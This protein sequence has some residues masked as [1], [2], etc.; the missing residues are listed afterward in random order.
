M[1]ERNISKENEEVMKRRKSATQRKR[2]MGMRKGIGGREVRKRGMDDEKNRLR[3]GGGGGVKMGVKW[4]MIL[5]CARTHY[6]IL[7][8]TP[9]CYSLIHTSRH[10]HTH[11]VSFSP[12][13]P[14]MSSDSVA[15]WW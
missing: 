3:A 6:Y 10:T 7:I 8:H 1:T 15:L 11:T 12:L 5:L 2:G 14:S 13:R 4:A 9:L